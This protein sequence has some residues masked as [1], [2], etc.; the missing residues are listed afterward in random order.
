M[1]SL[2]LPELAEEAV[3][4]LPLLEWLVQ[5]GQLRPL[6]DGRFDARDA[7]IVSTAQALLESGIAQ[8]DLAWAFQG[9]GAG[10]A[11]VGRMFAV[12]PPRSSRTYAKV[13]ESL[14]STGDRLHAIYA[15]LGLSEPAPDARL[16]E[17]EEAAVVG[18]AGI[19][20]DVDPSGEA[21]VRVARIAGEALRRLSEAWLDVWDE[22][23]Q[24]EL[25]SQGSAMR[26]GHTMPADLTDPG[27]NAALMSAGVARALVMWLHERSLERTL[28]ARIIN[29]FENALIRAGRLEARPARPPAIA[30]VDLSGYTSM[31]VEHGDEAAATVADQLRALAETSV[32][33][34]GGR[35]VKLLGDG[36]LMQFPDAP[37]A[38]R[39]TLDLVDRIAAAG[40][41]R[42]HAGIAAGRVVIRDGDVFGATVNLA[43]RIADIAGPNQVVVEEG[44]VVMLPRGTATFHP[45]GRVD[46]KGF[47]DP[48]ALWR[49]TR[50]RTSAKRQPVGAPGLEDEDEG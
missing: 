27:Q 41:P 30:F 4:P 9:A 12:P 7:A 44:V 13:V 49:A 17:D 23:A 10:L 50:P 40:M 36:V 35:L 14:G 1:R 38:I 34:E 21:D 26:P 25:R 47:P 31:T 28:N 15:A 32:R 29:A 16:R 3:A 18:F 22:V 19:W 45:I 37:S 20:A 8:D 24:P 2:T 43:S 33:P 42:A 11:A 6:P 39:A 46:L 48:V 5:V